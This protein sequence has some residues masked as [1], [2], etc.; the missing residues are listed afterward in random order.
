MSADKADV[1]AFIFRHLNPD[2]T[3]KAYSYFKC[4]SLHL[5]EVG[6][7]LS[8]IKLCI[9]LDVSDPFGQ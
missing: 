6:V 5:S 4:P 7:S 2:V 9:Y 3:A 1:F 8:S